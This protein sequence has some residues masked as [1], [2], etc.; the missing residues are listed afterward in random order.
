ME[1]VNEA[2]QD[3]RDIDDAL[4]DGFSNIQ[5]PASHIDD[6]ALEAELDAIMKEEGGSVAVDA[7]KLP[8]QPTNEL[9]ELPA[10]PRERVGNVPA[11]L[12]FES[13]LR[14]LRQ[15]INA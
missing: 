6:N 4:R 5:L 2:M 7:K 13:R 11:E 1:S 12:D 10:V 8:P 9:P 3:A 15:G 14:R